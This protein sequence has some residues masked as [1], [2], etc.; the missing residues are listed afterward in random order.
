M[1]TWSCST[2]DRPRSGRLPA[3]DCQQPTCSPR[4]I[5]RVVQNGR[6]VVRAGA[7]V[8]TRAG[9]RLLQRGEDMSVASDAWRVAHAAAR[10]AQVDVT[11]LAG[12]DVSVAQGLIE[13]VWG[14]GE[15]PQENLLVALAHAGNTLL[16]ATRNGEPTGFALGFLGWTGGIHLHSH[17]TAVVAGQQCRGVGY[18]LKLWQRAICLREGIDEMRWTYDPLIARNAHFNLV[19]LGADVVAFEPDFYGVMDDAVN[20]GDHSDRFEVS[21]RLGSR[22][23]LDAAA[24]S[25]AAPPGDVVESLE[26]PPDYDTLRRTDPQLGRQARLRSRETFERVWSAGLGIEWSQGRYVFV[27]RGP[28]GP[29]AHSRGA[30]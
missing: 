16:A 10:A 7:Y 5:D 3:A 8:G 24:G 29:G 12:A 25:P 15:V 19:K 22:R 4:G 26:I 11:E 6:P 21:W 27:R 13:Q 2:H 9:R 20:A 1:P 23:A 14:A 17:M 18:A 28:A 30:A